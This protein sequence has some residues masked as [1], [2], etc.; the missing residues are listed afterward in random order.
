MP[1]ETALAKILG[2]I[3][4]ILVIMVPVVVVPYV[5]FKLKEKK[6][7]SQPKD[8][9]LEKTTLAYGKADLKEEKK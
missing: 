7:R 9:K 5:R 1:H 2:I 8:Q 3:L 6:L 4:F